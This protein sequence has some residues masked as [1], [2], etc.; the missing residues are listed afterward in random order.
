[1]QQTSSLLL[2]NSHPASRSPLHFSGRW[3]WRRVAQI[4]VLAAFVGG[5][6]GP[7]AIRLP[8][9]VDGQPQ[10]KQVAGVPF[11]PQQAYQCGPAALAMTLAWSG[12]AVRPPDLVPEVF[13]ASRKGS[14]QASMIAA[15]RRHGRVAYLLDS[16]QSLID[17]IAAGHPVV[18]LQN[19][20]LEWYPVW[21][22]AVVIGWEANG[23]MTLHTGTRSAASTARKTFEHTWARSDYWGL[24]VLPPSRLPAIAV[25]EEYLTAVSHLE[26]LENWAAA[27]Q[28]Y[29]TALGR[30]PNSLPAWVGTG[31]CLFQLGDLASAEAQ[32][33]A[34]GKRF[35][36]E[37]VVFNN[38]AQVLLE[39]GRR[40]EALD[41][42]MYA[43][44]C[45]GPLKSHFE[46]TLEEIRN[47]KPG[48]LHKA[49]ENYPEK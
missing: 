44:E 21:H 7:A 40:G 33:R 39:Q 14:L 43:I 34:A 25:E 22:Y 4:L 16:P 2:I 13:T 12:I 38:L 28:G 49:D 47:T 27:A 24:L 41:A 36:Q 30:W 5:C 17:E 3:P 18:V 46:K 20:G 8:V 37:G 15:V 26:R 11:F 35:P 48:T 6:A 42:V 29:R 23:R 31:V 10:P 32:F 45:G 1:V 9:S 19:L